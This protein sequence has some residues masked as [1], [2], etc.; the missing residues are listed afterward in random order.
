MFAVEERF[1]YLLDCIS[2]ACECADP[3][4]AT[5]LRR[6]CVVLVCGFVERSVELVVL[7]RLNNR[8]HPRLISFVRSHFKRGTNYDCNAIASLIEKFDSEWSRKFT[9]FKVR[10]DKEVDGLASLYGL[11]NVIAHGNTANISAIDLQERCKEAK[12]IVDAL[13]SSTS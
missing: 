6:H 5:H 2:T 4:I 9:E 8:A 10:N 13:I 3:K 7:E 1:K 11:R 12:A